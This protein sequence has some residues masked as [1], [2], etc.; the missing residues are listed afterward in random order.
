MQKQLSKTSLEY[1][2]KKITSRVSE[3]RKKVESHFRPWENSFMVNQRLVEKYRSLPV[4]QVLRKALEYD[5]DGYSSKSLYIRDFY[6]MQQI[7]VCKESMKAQFENE[8]E[9]KRLKAELKSILIKYTNALYF[10]NAEPEKLF[11][12]LDEEIETR[13]YSQLNN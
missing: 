10:Q 13:V 3:A 8:S 7:N 6:S 4:R 11:F 5:E 1:A 2:E 9:F 12:D